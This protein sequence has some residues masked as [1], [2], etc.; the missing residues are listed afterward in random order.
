MN[1]QHIPNRALLAAAVA[2]AL[3]ITLAVVALA[4]A[5]KVEVAQD[6][7]AAAAAERELS[8]ARGQLAAA[9]DAAYE[10][11]GADQPSLTAYAAPLIDESAEAPRPPAEVRTDPA[12]QQAQADVAAAEAAEEQA[13]TMDQGAHPLRLIG[14]AE[15]REVFWL[16][17]PA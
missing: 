3:A 13:D 9:T 17:E 6:S 2:L 15:G 16:T 4:G 11:A 5:Y 8:E 7:R 14:G 1:A 12:L 10:R